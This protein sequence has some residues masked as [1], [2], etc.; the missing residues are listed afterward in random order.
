MSHPI[1][2]AHL[3]AQ[4]LTPPELVDV[5]ARAGYDYVGVRLLSP[6]AGVIAY[7]LM[8]NPGMLRETLARLKDTGVAVLDIEIARLN[9]DFDAQA[10]LPFFDIGAQL[11]AC[12]ILVAGDDPNPT[13]LAQSFAAFCETAKPFGLR[14][15][16]EY[17]P[18]TAV[19]DVS[20]AVRLVTEAGSPENAGVLVDAIHYERSGGTLDEIA[21]LPRSLLYYAQLSDAPAGIPDSMEEILRQARYE[22][23]LPGHGGI[24]LHGILSVLPDDLPISIEVWDEVRTPAIGM[25]EWAR[26]ALEAARKTIDPVQ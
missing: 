13:R 12:A 26:M 1:S 21:A 19:P 15:N 3:T 24:D 16:I 22:R 20:T 23:L 14:P 8:E 4:R 11:G 17:M 9:E 25:A 5:A 6:A 7:P 2:L 10:F 18:W